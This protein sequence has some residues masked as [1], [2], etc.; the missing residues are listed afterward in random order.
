MRSHC[1]P[2]EAKGRDQ[3]PEGE[4][5]VGDMDGKELE[6]SPGLWWEDQPTI[7]ADPG[8]GLRA[9]VRVLGG[10]KRSLRGRPQ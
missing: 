1:A 4:A 10:W 5:R 6:V 3:G 8:P 9:G 7:A 2:Q